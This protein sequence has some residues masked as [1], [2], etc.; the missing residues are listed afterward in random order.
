M[1]FRLDPS[2]FSHVFCQKSFSFSPTFSVLQL[3]SL[4]AALPLEDVDAMG[5]PTSVVITA[6]HMLDVD[7]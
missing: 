6:L 7:R 2:V 3:T 4:P 5:S 1:S